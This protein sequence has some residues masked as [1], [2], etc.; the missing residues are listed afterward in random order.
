MARDAVEL[1]ELE[2]HLR[3]TEGR[4]FGERREAGS[5]GAVTRAD[6]RSRA[7]RPSSVNRVVACAATVKLLGFQPATV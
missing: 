1:G 2:Q 6:S 5:L 3:L 7:C 4:R